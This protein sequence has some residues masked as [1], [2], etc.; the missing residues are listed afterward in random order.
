MI[1]LPIDHS[2]HSMLLAVYIS[3]FCSVFIFWSTPKNVVALPK[4]MDRTRVLR[5]DIYSSTSFINDA[6]LTKEHQAPP[7]HVG[8]EL[9]YPGIYMRGGC[10]GLVFS[11]IYIGDLN[12]T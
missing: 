4:N 5:Y 2:M 8:L 7:L 1:I 3:G 12:R 6:S 9:P 10:S 11:S